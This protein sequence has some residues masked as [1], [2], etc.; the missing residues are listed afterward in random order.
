MRILFIAMIGLVGCVP[1]KPVRVAFLDAAVHE[2]SGLVFIDS[3][4]WTINDSQ[5][6]PTLFRV[7]ANGLVEDSVL[8]YDASNTDWEDLSS[9]SLFVYIADVGNN[10]Q[11]RGGF[12]VHAISRRDFASRDSSI[13][14]RSISFGRLPDQ[15]AVFPKVGRRNFD[16]EAVF[17]KGGHLYFISK[18]IKA[19]GKSYGK[20]YRVPASQ[21]SGGVQ[22]IDSFQFNEPITSADYDAASNRLV[23]TGYLS[24]FVFDDFNENNFSN[25]SPR[26]FRYNRVRQYE[27]ITFDP[28]KQK[29]LLSNEKGLGKKSALFEIPV[30]R[31]SAESRAGAGFAWRR[32][33]LTAILWVYN[34]GVK[35]I[36]KR[37]DL[38][39]PKPVPPSRLPNER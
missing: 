26:R 14:S 33:K 22:L 38:H 37:N 30:E 4:L 17:V 34:Y 5:N 28:T 23:A 1:L 7:N 32:V 11:V 12:S 8:V 36:A 3:T 10:L 25:S 15:P 20:L 21:G 29:L 24:L 2:T 31:L 9:D 13:G 39:K 6:T 35:R 18:N 27:S 19:C 16:V